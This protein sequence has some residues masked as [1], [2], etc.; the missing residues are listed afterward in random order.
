MTRGAAFWSVIALVLVLALGAPSAAAQ[1]DPTDAGGP[2]DLVDATLEQHDVRMS[3]R[4]ATA[5]AWTHA[6]VAGSDRRSLCATLADGEPAV[7]RG[8]VCVAVR[9][10]RSALSYTSLAADGS[11]IATRRLAADV[12]HPAPGVLQATFLP[13]AAGLAVGPFSWSVQSEW[14]DG[15]ACVRACV[16]RL[17]DAG[18]VSA[19]VALLADPPCFGA[20]A[21][22][23]DEPCE[24][25][26]LRLSV[27]PALARAGVLRDPYCDK[28][29]RPGLLSI[30]AFGA[31]PDGAASSF[32][33][34]GDS[35]AA[36][37]KTALEVVTLAKRWRG[38]SIFRATCPATRARPVLRT[39]PRSRQCARWNGELLDWIADHRDVETVVLA[40]HAR[41]KVAGA[42]ASAMF[43]ALRAGYRGEISALLALGRRV[44]VIRDV[45]A[46]ARDHLQCVAAALDGGRP[47][48]AVCSRPRGKALRRDPLVAAARAAG[49]SR[50]RVVDL[51]DQ[52]CDASRCFA[53]VG[54]ALVQHDQTHMTSTFSATLGPF[55][56][57]A[58]GD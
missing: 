35:H 47:A 26:D 7:A 38:Y 11:A 8:R 33:L 19:Q 22:D 34:V 17:P 55:I 57:R 44:V 50:V 51:T 52:F 2:L 1:P 27:A 12:S 15:G 16:D 56:L 53:V 32:A 5:G 21:R 41:A 54:G 14:T 23:P 31:P 46:S 39:R 58:L 6:D 43:D 28:R 49:S 48:D 10:R 18:D 13:V 9:S 30:C 4:I 37:L 20:A 3:L 36:S 29:M 25:P 24:N 40:A 45:P 42:T